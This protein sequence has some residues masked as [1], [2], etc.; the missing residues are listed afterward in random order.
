AANGPAPD[1]T[2]Q[3]APLFKQY[4]QGCHNAKDK[5]GGLVLESYDAL[6]RG[7]DEGAVF[8]PGK[9]EASRLLL[10]LTGKAEPAMPP[11]GNEGPTAAEIALLKAWLDAGAKGPSGEKPDPTLLVTPKVPLLAPARRV[12]NAAAISPDGKLAALAG[13]GEVRLVA[14]DSRQTVRTLGGHRGA[15]TE[16]VFS[17]D[18]S[19]LLSAAGE[20]GL[21]GELKIWN[22][23][24]G[25]LLRT[26]IGHSDSL[27][28]CALS[29]DGQW[30]AS[31]G[32]DQQIKLWDAATGQELRTLIGHNG[33]IFGLAFSPHGKLLASASADR[34]VKLWDPATGARLDTFGQPL[35]E[36]YAVAFS[37]DGKRVIG[38][39]VDNRIR[40]WQISDTAQEGTNPLLLTRFAHEG[41]VIR[42]AYSRDGKTI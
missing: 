38:G 23:A 21:F 30:I 8:S 1:Y 29:P 35:K 5:E 13:Y 39:G 6:L 10:V 15:V 37:P 17:A 16:V 34:T 26:I 33:A 31:G 7:G 32:Y 28:A 41:A 14:L 25:A 4:C 18:G 19:R 9:S 3:I 2:R 11:E 40:V 27:Y 12:I 20:P 36:Q 42:L 24:D 22:T